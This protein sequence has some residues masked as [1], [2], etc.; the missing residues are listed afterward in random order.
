MFDAREAKD[1]GIIDILVEPKTSYIKGLEIAESLIT[2]RSVEVIKA[3]V[4]LVRNS[5]K[6]EYSQA[7]QRETELF[8]DLARKALESNE[9]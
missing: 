8:C 5:D 3:V 4:E 2:R 6:L 9:L 1:F 7:L